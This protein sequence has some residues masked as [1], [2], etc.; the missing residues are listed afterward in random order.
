MACV[1]Y[2]GDNGYAAMVADVDVNQA[3]GAVAVK[4]RVSTRVPPAAESEA[5]YWTI[6]WPVDASYPKR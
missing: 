6:T 5:S 2:E 3:T 4:R 1:L